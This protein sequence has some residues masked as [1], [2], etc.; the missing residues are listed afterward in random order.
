MIR[1]SQRM[2]V[3]E[4]PDATRLIA[5]MARGEK[6]AADELYPLVYQELRSLAGQILRGREG[7]NTLQATA[8]VHEAFLRLCPDSGDANPGQ[9]YGGRAHFLGVAAKA[10]RSVLV[11]HARAKG[12]QKRGG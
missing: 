8:L 4:Q 2:N 11:D 10:M 1:G 9:A 6:G 5:R 3:P 12:A 7:G